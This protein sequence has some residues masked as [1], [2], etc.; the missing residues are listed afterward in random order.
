MIAYED[1]IVMFEWACGVQKCCL[2]RQFT[3]FWD[4]KTPTETPSRSYFGDQIECFR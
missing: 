1:S 4:I 3:G 2:G